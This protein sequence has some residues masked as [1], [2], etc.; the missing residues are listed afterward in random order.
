MK[1]ICALLLFFSILSCN[2]AVVGTINASV[3]PGGTSDCSDCVSARANYTSFAQPPGPGGNDGKLRAT[4]SNPDD[5]SMTIVLSPVS[6][7]FP[8]SSYTIDGSTNLLEAT[9]PITTANGTDMVTATA[10]SGFINLNAINI[11]ATTGVI[12]SMS[13][14]FHVNFQGSGTAIGTIEY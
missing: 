9:F 14:E 1:R 8:V 12:Q 13:A 11:D 3:S 5:Y 10:V 4:L 2:Q 6:G 7:A